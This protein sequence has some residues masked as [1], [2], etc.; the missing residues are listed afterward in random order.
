MTTQFS[1]RVLRAKAAIDPLG[2]YSI[3]QVT[4]TFLGPLAVYRKRVEA[5]QC[6]SILIIDRLDFP[7][8]GDGEAAAQP[9]EVPQPLWRGWRWHLV[10]DIL[11]GSNGEAVGP[12]PLRNT[13]PDSFARVIGS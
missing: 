3:D 1:A 13:E 4:A 11:A 2:L 9:D 7:M 8:N 5:F 6:T 12:P 10:L